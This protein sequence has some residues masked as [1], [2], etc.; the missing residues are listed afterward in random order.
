MNSDEHPTKV[1]GP[2]LWSHLY[3]MKI[4]KHRNSS[5]KEGFWCDKER[6][7]KGS[8]LTQLG[9]YL[10]CFHAYLIWFV[11]YLFSSDKEETEKGST[12]IPF[13][14]LFSRVIPQL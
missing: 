3:R 10:F 12:L 2:Q 6:T 11:A 8:Y 9:C 7:K 4:G 5:D 14:A 1:D 13:R